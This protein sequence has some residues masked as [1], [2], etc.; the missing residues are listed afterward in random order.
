[1]G[2][3]LYCDVEAKSIQDVV[4]QIEIGLIDPICFIEDKN[5]GWWDYGAIDEIE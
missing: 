5:S 3:D 1:M 4:N 2:S